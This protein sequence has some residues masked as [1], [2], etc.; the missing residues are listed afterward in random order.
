MLW[1]PQ[2]KSIA[3]RDLIYAPWVPA[4]ERGLSD[5]VSP[6]TVHSLGVWDRAN[7][8]LALAP[9][10]SPLA[11]VGGFPWFPPGV[12]VS[13][14]GTWVSDGVVSLARFEEGHSLVLLA[15]HR[16][17]YCGFPFDLIEISGFLSQVQQK[18]TD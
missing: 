3:G 17:Q 13:F 14:L 10:T 9:Q 4:G 11:P 7:G 1:V 18:L 2:E 8:R 16:E 12:R 6:L 15:T 5:W